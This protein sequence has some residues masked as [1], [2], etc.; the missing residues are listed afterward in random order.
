MLI[1]STSEKEVY[2][3]HWLAKL[4]FEKDGG[5]FPIAN[6]SLAFVQ[7]WITADEHRLLGVQGYLE[8][9]FSCMLYRNGSL[10]C[11]AFAHLAGQALITLDDYQ[12]AITTQPVEIKTGT[13]LEKEYTG[14]WEGH[15]IRVVVSPWLRHS[16]KTP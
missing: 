2:N 5:I 4:Y 14:S 11:E 1:Q 13:A 15:N 3:G 9:W 6:P 16:N 10:S 7:K 8:S 12:K